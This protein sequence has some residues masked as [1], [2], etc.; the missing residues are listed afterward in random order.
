[1]KFERNKNS[2]QSRDQQPGHRRCVK[3]Q[4]GNASR[5]VNHRAF[6][7][8]DVSRGR[9]DGRLFQWNV[10]GWNHSLGK[11]F[12]GDGVADAPRT[13]NG[14]PGAEAAGLAAGDTAGAATPDLGEAAG[15]A[16]APGWVD[17]GA[18]GGFT[19]AAG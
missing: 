4:H 6:E 10:S 13:G 5:R 1:M 18:D 16:A 7:L 14:L 2:Q 19:A 8:L 9:R 15:V 17:G 11:N 12:H 3:H